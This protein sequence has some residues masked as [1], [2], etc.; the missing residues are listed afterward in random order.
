[1]SLADAMARIAARDAALTVEVGQPCVANAQAACAG[2]LCPLW[3]LDTDARARAYFR[4]CDAYR[5]IMAVPLADH[6]TCVRAVP[7]PPERGVCGAKR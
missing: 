5:D 2:S 7:L 4:D 1:M 3:T 6:V